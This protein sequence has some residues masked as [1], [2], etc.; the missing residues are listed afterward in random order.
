MGYSSY[1][2]TGKPSPA[3]ASYPE[4]SSLPLELDSPFPSTLSF[5]VD[6]LRSC[7]CVCFMSST[8]VYC[9]GLL[10]LNSYLSAMKIKSRDVITAEASHMFA[11]YGLALPSCYCFVLICIHNGVVYSCSALPGTWRPSSNLPRGKGP[12]C[13]H[14]AKI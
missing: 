3:A 4:L 8:C 2:S 1:P 14:R 6:N 9:G 13:R 5:H 7:L 11:S 10:S 12:V